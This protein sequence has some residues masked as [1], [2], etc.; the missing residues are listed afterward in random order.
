MLLIILLLVLAENLASQYSISREEQDKFAMNSQNKAEKA[1]K[2]GMFIE[3]IVPVTV[4]SPK[5]DKVVSEDEHIRY[6]TTMETL[7]KLKPAFMKVRLIFR[8]P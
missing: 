2:Q 6:G 4:K 1:Q 5:G 7:A 8:L 3:E